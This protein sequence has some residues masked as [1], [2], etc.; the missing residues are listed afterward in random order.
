MSKR[1]DWLIVQ[2]AIRRFPDSPSRQ[3]DFVDSWGGIKVKRK[4]RHK[5][6]SDRNYGRGRRSIW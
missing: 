2:E 1:T 5:Q 4:V 3:R 6:R